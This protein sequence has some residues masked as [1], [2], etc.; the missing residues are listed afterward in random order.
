M[1]VLRHCGRYLPLKWQGR[2]LPRMTILLV[3]TKGPVAPGDPEGAGDG[4]FGVV[5]LARESVAS[6]SEDLLLRLAP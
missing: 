5:S 2:Q 6:S 3:A 1:V 4:R